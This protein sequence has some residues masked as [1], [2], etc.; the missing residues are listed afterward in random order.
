MSKHYTSQRDLIILTGPPGAGKSTYANKLG[1][2][3]Y[4]QNLGNKAQ[5][6]D[7]HD[8][9]SILVTSA[10]DREAKTYWLREATKFG[11]SRAKIIVYDPGRAVTVQRLIAREMESPEGHRRRL[12]KA[13]Q[14][15]YKEYSPHPEETKITETGE[16]Q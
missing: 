1:H 9:V 5:W 12:T 3:T 14:R 6:R 13:V 10:P 8:R 7:S 4:D 2:T 11:F 16:Y 15:W